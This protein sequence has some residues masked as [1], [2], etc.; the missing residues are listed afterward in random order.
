MAGGAHGFRGRAQGDQFLCCGRLEEAVQARR[1]AVALG[2]RLFDAFQLREELLEGVA[3]PFDSSSA[4]T[5]DLG[6]FIQGQTFSRPR[7]H[8]GEMK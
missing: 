8:S 3:H 7:Q 4:R 2:G 1:H 5:G 6:H